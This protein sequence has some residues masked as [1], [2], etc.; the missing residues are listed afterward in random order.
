MCPFKKDN[1][2]RIIDKKAKYEIEN[3]VIA[4]MFRD[5]RFRTRKVERNHKSKE[6][7]NERREK[8]KRRHRFQGLQ[9]EPWET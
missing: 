6:L 3:Q 5:K 7:Q 4:K 2:V 8:N 9:F 1:N